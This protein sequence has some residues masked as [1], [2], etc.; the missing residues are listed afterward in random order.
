MDCSFKAILGDDDNEEQEQE[1]D[2]DE[3]GADNMTR[4]RKIHECLAQKINNYGDTRYEGEYGMLIEAI[5][6]RLECR[7]VRAEVAVYGFS[8]NDDRRK[9]KQAEQLFWR[10]AIDA[11]GV[12][13]EGDLFLVE[14]KS[15]SRTKQFID[16]WRQPNDRGFVPAL[17]QSLLYRKL[18][19]IHLAAHKDLSKIFTSP[20]GIMIVPVRMDFRDVNDTDPRICW[21]FEQIKKALILDGIENLAWKIDQFELIKR[22]DFKAKLFSSKEGSNR[23]WYR[24]NVEQVDG[25]WFL[26][27]TALLTKIFKRRAK[28]QDLREALTLPPLVDVESD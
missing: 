15:S 9:A 6:N 18:L 20:L 26:K 14:W 5:E 1:D 22:V 16:F 25:N 4:G 2:A 28:V 21:S 12:T 27:D 24:E 17:H 11:I 23:L 19:E 7:F 13:K 3:G 10:G 8:L